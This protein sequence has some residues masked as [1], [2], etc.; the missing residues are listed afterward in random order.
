M[1]AMW[2]TAAL[3]FGRLSA[4]MLTLPVMSTVGLPRYV[5]ILV[6]VMLTVLILPSVPYV[7]DPSLSVMFL[8]FASE[9]FLGASLGLII[10]AAFS[11]FA[12]AA[13]MM[14]RQAALGMSSLTDPVMNLGQSPLGVVASWLAGFVFLGANQHL[15]VLEALAGSFHRVPPGHLVDVGVLTQALHDGIITA[16]V[17]GTQLAGPI[18]ALVFLVNVFIG[19]LAK[20]APRM[21]V[22]FSVGM[23]VNSIIGIWLFGVAL[24]WMLDV[25]GGV[26]D[27][28][29]H[30]V[31]VLI[32]G[33]GV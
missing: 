21:N 8:G 18:I 28:S 33:P 5:G 23:T 2:V 29:I 15:R 13:E 10:R 31:L 9:V 1:T 30:E 14:S 7:E 24:P 12:V 11:S 16:L 19:I 27:A 32:L 17:V 20:L 26:V 6:S 3:V 22:F 25:H 4:L